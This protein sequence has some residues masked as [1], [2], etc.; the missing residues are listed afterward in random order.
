MSTLRSPDVTWQRPHVGR[1]EIEGRLGQRG[2]VVW[3]TGLSASGKSTLARLSQRALFDAGHLAIVLDGDNVRHGLCGDLG[4]APADRSENV[5]RVAHV[6]RLFADSGLLVIVAL[7]SPYREDRDRAREIC[8][9]DFLEVYVETSVETCEK[10]D[11][12]GLYKKARAGQIQEFTGISA[13][14]EAPL[15]PDFV[16]D[17][18][19]TSAVDSSEQ[20]LEGLREKGIVGADIRRAKVG[21]AL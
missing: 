7:I 13:P 2:A 11:P 17:C 19:S 4:F 3:L 1:E 5:R 6:A 12:K 18:E 8:N 14:Y 20:L 15:R 10:R 9:P 16:I 21:S